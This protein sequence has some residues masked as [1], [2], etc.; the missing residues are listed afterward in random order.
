[1]NQNQ[2]YVRLVGWGEP[3]LSGLARGCIMVAVASV[4]GESEVVTGGQVAPM[5]VPAVLHY[6]SVYGCA[7]MSN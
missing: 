1:M 7:V 2:N 5:S 3:T 6:M 4:T